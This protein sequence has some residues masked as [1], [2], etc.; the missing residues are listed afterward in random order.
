[1]AESPTQPA[2][3]VP[4]PT[5]IVP[6]TVAIL[7]APR[8]LA[9]DYSAPA[10]TLGSH[11][12]YRVLACA[13]APPRFPVGTTHPLDAADDAD[14]VVVPGF[15]DPEIPLSKPYVD[16]IRRAADRDARIVA[17]CTGAFALADA[18]ILDGRQATTHWEFVPLLRSLRPRVD[19]LDNNLFVEDGRILTSAGSG[20]GVDACLHVIRSDYGPEVAYEIGKRVGY[21]GQHVDTLT[22]SRSDLSATRAWVLANI[23]EQVTVQRMAEHSNMPRRTFI[24]HFETETGMPPMRWVVLQRVQSARRL[25]ERSDWSVER[26]AA[27]TGF[28][29][30]A[31]FRTVFRREVGTTPS[32]YRS[33][34]RS[35][36]GLAQHT[37]AV[38]GA[39]GSNGSGS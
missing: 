24:R 17:I 7:V 9:I 22:P 25:L 38:P 34:T 19:V 31:N 26:I 23:G 2:A 14:I 18:G 15:E 37:N 35:E 30:A 36:T 39:D 27:V 20:A 28:G 5:R 8:V 10:R 21:V 13:D 4:L 12:G 6:L 32:G 33:T 1:M 3:A 16:T 29:T 11:S